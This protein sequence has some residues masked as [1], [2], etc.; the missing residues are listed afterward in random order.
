MSNRY[1]YKPRFSF[2]NAPAALLRANRRKT[3]CKLKR[4]KQPSNTGLNRELSS[5]PIP[6]HPCQCDPD[7]RGFESIEAKGSWHQWYHY[8]RGPGRRNTD[9]PRKSIAQQARRRGTDNDPYQHNYSH[10]HYPRHHGF[11]RCEPDPRGFNTVQPKLCPP[12][13]RPPSRRCSEAN[14]D[15]EE[16]DYTPLRRFSGEGSEDSE[17]GSRYYEHYDM[18]MG[19]F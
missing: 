16:D 14:P 9:G 6:I 7:P 4:Y 10:H 2:E 5:D 11:C 15:E 13:E 3:S 8:A 19:K 1:D 18:D 12:E 17:Y